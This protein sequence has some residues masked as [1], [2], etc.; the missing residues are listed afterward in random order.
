[1]TALLFSWSLENVGE[2]ALSAVLAVEVG[3]H[4]DAGTALLGGAFTPQAL[5]LAVVVH[6]VVFKHGQLDFLVLM[7]DLLGGGVVLLLALLAATAKAEDQVQ[8]G[9]CKQTNLSKSGSSV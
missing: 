5:D 2:S 3:G 7:L 8:G 4:E 1:M 9:L 6:L